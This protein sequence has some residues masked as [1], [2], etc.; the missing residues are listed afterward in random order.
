VLP[1][2]LRRRE[3]G[4][5][6]GSLADSVLGEFTRKHETNSRL[7]FSRRQSRLLVVSGKLSGLCSNALKDVIDERVHDAHTL[8][9]DSSIGM[10]LLEH[11]VDV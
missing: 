3:L 4:D 1:A 10:D 8:L 9:R 7:N 5:S 2:C 11:L 6:L